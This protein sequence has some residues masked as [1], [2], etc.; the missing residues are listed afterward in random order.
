MA[1]L[2]GN[3][4]VLRALVKS[5]PNNQ[6]NGGRRLSRLILMPKYKHI[7]NDADFAAARQQLADNIQE[8]LNYDSEE[9]WNKFL[10]KKKGWKPGT[11]FFPPP[12]DYR[13][14]G[15]GQYEYLHHILVYPDS[16][17]G[18]WQLS[19]ADPEKFQIYDCFYHS[20]KVEGG[21]IYVKIAVLPD[22]FSGDS[23]LTPSLI[24]YSFH[25]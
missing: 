12:R 16:E 2:F 25:M 6:L 22:K 21:S 14:N 3:L 17:S 18:G 7:R 1:A 11:C 9:L 15:I 20:Q 13:L 24:G 10:M 5:K 19:E 8:L 4:Y 23:L